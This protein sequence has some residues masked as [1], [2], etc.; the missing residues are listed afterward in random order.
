NANMK[1]KKTLESLQNENPDIDFDERRYQD[2]SNCIIIMKDKETSNDF[3]PVSL[4]KGNSL[5]D[6]EE[7]ENHVR[8]F[9]EFKG[10]FNRIII[11]EDEKTSNDF[12]P[13]SLQKGH[14]MAIN[15]AEDERIICK[16]TINYKHS[17][18]YKPKNPEKL[19]TSIQQI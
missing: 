14:I 16:Y 9:A 10:Y 17:G 11:I 15:N 8:K 2:V 19:D 1:I 4:Q 7:A 3:E 13:V 5:S 18:V 6:F 12:E